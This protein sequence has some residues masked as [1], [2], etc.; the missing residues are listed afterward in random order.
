MPARVYTAGEQRGIHRVRHTYVGKLIAAGVDL[1]VVSQMLGHR[2]LAFA[3]RAG[4]AAS[5]EPRVSVA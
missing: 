1:Y 4:A 3:F 2:S 5:A